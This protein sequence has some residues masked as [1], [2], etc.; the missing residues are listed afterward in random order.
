VNLI[1]IN[2]LAGGDIGWLV[3]CAVSY[4]VTC[5]IAHIHIFSE[6]LSKNS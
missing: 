4:E 3:F 1:N 5:Q 6:L 2:E